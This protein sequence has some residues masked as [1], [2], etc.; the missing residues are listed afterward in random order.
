MVSPALSVCSIPRTSNSVSSISFSNTARP[1]CIRLD[2]EQS[3]SP[4]PIQD[5]GLSAERGIMS[6]VATSLLEPE[7]R[8]KKAYFTWAAL[9]W[10]GASSPIRCPRGKHPVRFIEALLVHLPWA[11]QK[12]LLPPALSAVP[13]TPGITTPLPHQSPGSPSLPPTDL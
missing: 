2:L 12:P 3:P 4:W 9:S 11:Q 8:P 1:L 13:I 7:M 5:F 6:D 10:P